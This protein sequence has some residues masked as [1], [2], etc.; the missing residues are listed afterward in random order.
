MPND[1]WISQPSDKITRFYCGDQVIIEINKDGFFYKGEKVEDAHHVYERVNELVRLLSK[2]Q[3]EWFDARGTAV[4]F[5][6]TA[7]V[8][9]AIIVWNYYFYY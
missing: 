3:R 7:I 4:C 8:M 9:T 6:S 2:Q 1:I 5:L